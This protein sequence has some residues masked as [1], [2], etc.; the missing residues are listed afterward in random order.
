MRKIIVGAQV[1]MDGV[2]QAPGGPTEDPTKGFK[3]GGWAMPYF[4]QEFGEEIERVFKQPFDLLLGRKTYEIFAAY[5]PYYDEDAPHGSIAKRFREIKKYAVSRSG[6]VDTSW[7]GSVLLRDIADVK[8][9]KREDGA[10]LVTQGSTEL[11]HALLAHDLVDAISIFT[12]PVVLGSGKKLF[13]DG[14]AAHSFKL[15]GSRACSNG[16]IVGH[17]ERAGE[18][19]VDDTALGSPSDREILRQ[20]RMKREG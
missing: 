4:D 9:L 12:L 16:L 1:S 10:N 7:T 11:V 18:I 6:E 13:A 3:F 15:T 8:R 20:D 14:S 17:Y 19:K 5:W 2:M